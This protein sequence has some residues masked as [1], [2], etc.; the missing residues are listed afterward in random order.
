MS[1]QPKPVDPSKPDLEETT[2]VAEA[3]AD[4]L[5]SAGAAAREQHLRENG[6]EPVS[7][8]IMITGFIVA[9]VGG[10]VLFS[11]GEMFSYDSFVKSGYVQALDETGPAAI[12]MKPA[13]E[14]YMAKGAGL[15][16]QCGSCHGSDGAGAGDYPPLAGSEW[17]TESGVVPALAIIH[18]VSGP[19]VVA[20]KTYGGVSMPVMGDGMSDFEL[21]SLVYYVQNSWGN[22]VGKIYSPEQIAQIREISNKYGKDAMTSDI[23]KKNLDLKLEG[24]YLTPETM[25]NMKTGEVVE[26][27]Q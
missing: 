23:L 21:A 8:W 14:A 3:H 17:V 24:D 15:F 12:P 5:R 4:V 10:S 26:A 13:G 2:N 1:N 16:K 27:A 11:S 22:A 7:M 25:L 20:G 19:L 18:G 9:L 6:L